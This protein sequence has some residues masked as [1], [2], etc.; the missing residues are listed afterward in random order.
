MEQERNGCGVL[1]LS[2][3]SR[4]RSSL[5]GADQAAAEVETARASRNRWTHSVDVDGTDDRAGGQRVR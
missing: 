1:T 2:L 3:N 4:S 5:T